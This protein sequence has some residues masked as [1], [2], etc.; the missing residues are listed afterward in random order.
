MLALGLIGVH[1]QENGSLQE[2]ERAFVDYCNVNLHQPVMTFS[3]DGTKGTD[4]AYR[5][6]IEHMRSSSGEYLVVV[7]DARH[8]GDDLESVARS[9]VELHGIGASV[10]CFDENFPDPLQNAFQTLGIKG[11]SRTRSHRIRESMRA[12]ALEGQVLGRPPFGYRIG[13]EGRLEVVRDE[14][15][16][17]ELIYRLHTRDGQG[18]RLIAQQLNERGITTRRGGNWN[19]ATLRDILRN[20][21][22][23]GTYTR[24]GMRR[25]RAHEAIISH[26]IFRSAQE[27]TKERRPLGRVVDAKPFLLSRAMFC[28][29]CGNKMMG[30]TRRQSWKRKDGRRA[31]GVYRYYQCQSR[32][33]QSLCGYH[34]WRES[35]LENAVLSQ[36]KYSFLAKE[37]HL[38]SDPEGEAAAQDRAQAMKDDRVRN[39]ERRF[40]RA[41]KRAARGDVSIDKLTQYVMALDAVRKGAAEAVQPADIDATLANWESLDMDTRRAFLV[42]HVARITVEDDS[43]EV[44]V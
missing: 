36:L 33:N 14:A 28:G 6:M 43:V 40:L 5:R 20:S 12:R 21:A 25:P 13:A 26:E 2:M 22:Y 15:N 42:E 34:T 31:R 18:V 16:V 9:V 32:N 11:V 10:A 4:T 39:A 29:Y 27:Q 44:V 37:S 19:V 41:M 30:V 23:T 38:R 8:L 17:V 35:A 24:L 1:D 3:S 7:P